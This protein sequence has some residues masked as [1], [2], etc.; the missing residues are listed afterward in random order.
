MIW[1]LL[2]AEGFEPV[3]YFFEMRRD[4]VMILEV[5]VD[6]V[7]DDGASNDKDNAGDDRED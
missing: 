5:G 4:S 6:A 2:F 7:N 3:F 1:I